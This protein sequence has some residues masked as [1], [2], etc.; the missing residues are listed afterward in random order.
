MIKKGEWKNI[1]SACEI[2]GIP[3]KTFDDYKTLL[4]RA[5]IISIPFKF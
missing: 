3:R 1:K 5:A 2:M 4:K